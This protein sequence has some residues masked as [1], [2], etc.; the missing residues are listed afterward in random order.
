MTN[1]LEDKKRTI[2]RFFH[3]L[4][5]LVQLDKAEI[6]SVVARTPEL[7]PK[8]ELLVL[9]YD[10]A[11]LNMELLATLSNSRQ[12][13]AI[14]ILTRAVFELAVEVK[15]IEISPDAVPKIRLFDEVQKLKTARN[16]VAYASKNPHAAVHWK[17]QEEFIRSRGK[18]IDEAKKRMWPKKDGEARQ[19]FSHWTLKNL[20]IRAEEL[21]EPFHEIYETQYSAMNFFAHPGTTG[22]RGIDAAAFAMLVGQS[23][24]IA[25][26]CYAEILHLIVDE[27]DIQASDGAIKDKIRD[28]RIYQFAENPAEKELLSRSFRRD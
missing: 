8:R 3:G 17:T 1:L 7:T 10:R 18:V 26:D 12:V 13:Q 25:A 2:D 16:I 20:R 28:V 9:N 5:W 19:D 21:K 24:K 22:V 14:V 4:Q 15:L 23:Y 27:F 11:A 6:R